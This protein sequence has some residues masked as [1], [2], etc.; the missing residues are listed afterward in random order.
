MKRILPAIIVVALI[1]GAVAWFGL[2]RP[3]PQVSAQLIAPAEDISGYARADGTRP[4]DLPAD[5]GPHPDY[6][7]EWWYYT[8]NLDAVDGRHFGYQLTFFRRAISPPDLRQPRDSNWAAD[9]LYLAHFTLTDVA[10]DEYRA[11]ERFTRGA[12]GLAGAQAEPYRVWLEDWQIEQRSPDVVALHALQDDIVIDLTLTDVKGTVLQGQAGYSPKG[13]EPGNASYYFS[14]TR[15]QTE[16]SLTTRGET[17]SVSGLSWMDHEFSTSALAP[18]QVGWDWFS[19]QL[20]DGSELMLFQFRR[21]DGSSDQFSSGTFIAAD[22]QTTHLAREDFDITVGD[23]WRSPR[24]GAEYPSQWE[25]RVPSLDLTLALEPYLSDQELNVFFV[26]WEGAVH[27]TGTRAGNA[28]A[29]NGYV[30]MTGYAAS[31]QGQF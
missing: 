10:R 14:Q 19:I 11:F 3:P 26:Y 2:S 22:G 16:G 9:H 8:G 1:V 5:F 13:S 4:L 17:F 28:V 27:I 30:E 24:S 15:L 25:L 6:L 20:D 21:E 18:E 29:G 7:T 12:A 23:T 31:M